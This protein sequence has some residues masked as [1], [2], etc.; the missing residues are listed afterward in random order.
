MTD[1]H[2]Y[3]MVVP[4]EW[5]AAHPGYEWCLRADV[6]ELVRDA[7]QRAGNA[8]HVLRTTWDAFEA[9]TV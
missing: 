9:D 2:R 7:T 5:I 3:L 6:T 4:L 1:P 8:V